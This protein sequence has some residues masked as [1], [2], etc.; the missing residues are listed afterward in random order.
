MAHFDAALDGQDPFAVGRRV[1]GHHVADVHHQVR[2][3]QVTAPVDAGEVEVEL[4]GAA[5][6]VTHLGHRAVGHHP[7]GLT[8]AH[9]PQVTW[10]AAK[11]VLDLA[12]RGKAKPVLQAFNFAGLDFVQAV[13]ATDQ[14]QPDGALEDV[15]R[16]VL[17]VGGQNQRLDRLRQRQAQQRGHVFA[18]AFAGR[19]RLDHGHRRRRTAAQQG[20]GFGE[21]DVGRIVTGGAVDDG[22]LTGIGDDLE[23]V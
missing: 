17:H 4:V 14:Q 21:F 10:F 13:I 19:G 9:R 7:H 15:A 2:L 11:V 16:L 20:Q 12:D 5:D 1:A 8:R 6:K 23:L 22:V 3:R 18:G